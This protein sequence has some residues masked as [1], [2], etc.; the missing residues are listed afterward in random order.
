MKM[1]LP[2]TPGHLPTDFYRCVRGDFQQS[3]NVY[4]CRG[5]QVFFQGKKI[6]FL[7]RSNCGIHTKC[8]PIRLK[9]E[10][11]KITFESL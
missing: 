11:L 10:I 9:Q 4:N 6:L 5:I 1:S 3:V 7:K 8:N 2:F